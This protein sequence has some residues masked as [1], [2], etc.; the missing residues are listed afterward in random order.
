M[1]EKHLFTKLWEGIVVN[2]RKLC[3]KINDHNRPKPN[4]KKPLSDGELSKGFIVVKHPG[5]EADSTW[6]YDGFFL[7]N[8]LL[9]SRWSKLCKENTTLRSSTMPFQALWKCRYRVCIS[10]PL[11]SASNWGDSLLRAWSNSGFLFSRAKNQSISVYLPYIEGK[12]Y[13]QT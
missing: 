12:E 9:W 10:L 7:A 4:Q 3:I 1:C 2:T 6:P 11:L 8:T 5:F 13:S